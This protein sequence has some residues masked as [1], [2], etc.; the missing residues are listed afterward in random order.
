M[1]GA[2]RDSL[3]S[4]ERFPLLGK[5]IT[6]LSRDVPKGYV[7]T[8]LG[9]NRFS[10]RSRK[11]IRPGSVLTIHTLTGSR[12][13]FD[14]RLIVKKGVSFVCSVAVDCRYSM[15]GEILVSDADIAYQAPGMVET[16]DRAIRIMTGKRFVVYKM[17]GFI[18]RMHHTVHRLQTMSAAR[19]RAIATDDSIT[20]A[21][22]FPVQFSE[23]EI[24][25][26]AGLLEHRW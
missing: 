14:G 1:Q 4:R 6:L 22:V 24:A 15:Q 25:F 23:E 16:I 17:T 9:K 20:A 12:F 2:L 18:D 26:V 7:F 10:I 11:T 3:F 21:G 8:P 13:V 5:V 19:W